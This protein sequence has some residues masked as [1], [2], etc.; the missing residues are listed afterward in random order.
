MTDRGEYLRA[1]AASLGAGGSHFVEA[2]YEEL[3]VG[4]VR[5]FAATYRDAE[6]TLYW[7]A[8]RDMT[9]SQDPWRLGEGS[10]PPQYEILGVGEPRAP[11]SGV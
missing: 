2:W 4:P 11:D 1:I 10:L 8:A 7:T 6:G 9:S 5:E 3:R